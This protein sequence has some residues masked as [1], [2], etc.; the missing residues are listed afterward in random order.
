MSD[1]D[2]LAHSTALPA[3]AGGADTQAA[4]AKGFH[5]FEVGD[6]QVSAVF[7]GATRLPFD[8]LMTGASPAE[9]RRK[10][11]KGGV[12]SPTDTPVNT[13]LV[14]TG[15]RRILV[16]AGAGRNFGGDC[17]KLHAHLKAA[18][19]EAGDIDAVVL[20]HMHPDHVGGLVRHGRIAFPKAE[21]FVSQAD[22][23]YWFD[24]ARE[25]QAPRG[26]KK[27]FKQSKAGVTPYL[28]REKV[29]PFAPGEILPG[30]TAI[31][32]PG[33]TAGHS[34]LRF[35]SAGEAI[36]FFGDLAHSAKV[37]M[38][39]PSVAIELDSDPSEAVVTRKAWFARFAREAALVAGAHMTFPGV[40]RVGPKGDAF[41]WLPA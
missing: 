20:T 39:D 34:L 36:V 24:E 13:Y 3:G 21:L 7:D 37:Q 14:D 23:D 35:E 2:C 1:H 5:R 6:L 10:L 18:G 12:A 4:R 16:D 31:A 26:R 29:R 25:A 41:E 9:I 19:Y 32:A 30:V 33:H 28:E 27:I 38:P 40:G 8:Q 22:L 17:G 15:E 11:A